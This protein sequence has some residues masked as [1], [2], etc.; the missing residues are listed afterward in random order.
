MLL[1]KRLKEGTALQYPQ[2]SIE[3]EKELL[4]PQ[5]LVTVR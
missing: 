3:E 5:I 2:E 4:R 1:R